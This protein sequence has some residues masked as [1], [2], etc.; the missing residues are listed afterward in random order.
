M[1]ALSSRLKAAAEGP[2]SQRHTR[3]KVRLVNLG[4]R[5]LKLDQSQRPALED[6]CYPVGFSKARPRG[7]GYHTRNQKEPRR[8][9]WPKAGQG[10][11]PRGGGAL[12][13]PL[14]QLR[15][16]AVQTRHR[17]FSVDSVFHSAPEARLCPLNLGGGVGVVQAP[18]PE[19]WGEG[20]A[21][22]STLATPRKGR[23]GDTE[24]PR[25][26]PMALEVAWIRAETSRNETAPAG[27]PEERA[28]P[29]AGG[30]H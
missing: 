4:T 30:R 13:F 25:G 2:T 29:E 27:G 1:R 17:F 22:W 19:S 23:T 15:P 26:Q 20:R 6:E 21:G 14:P 24:E 18:H 10:P 12:L 11:G 8:F 9:T 7:L 3:V 5:T 16:C 28:W